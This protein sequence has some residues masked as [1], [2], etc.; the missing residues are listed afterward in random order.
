MAFTSF[1]AA[2]TEPFF[3]KTRFRWYELLLG[4]LVL[5]GMCLVVQNLD[6]QMLAGF[7]IGIGSAFLCAVFSVRR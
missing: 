7:A 1:F 6:G 2:F 5:P 3:L 4:I